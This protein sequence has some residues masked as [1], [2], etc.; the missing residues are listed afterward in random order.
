[1]GA[2]CVDRRG[3][4]TRAL[5][6]LVLASAAACSL[7]PAPGMVRLDGGTVS[8]P[9]RPAVVEL[10]PFFVDQDLVSGS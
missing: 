2:V 8:L 9:G 4:L 1:M 5:P 3:S 6:L 10:E 7:P